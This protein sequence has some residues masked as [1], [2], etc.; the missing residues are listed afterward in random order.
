MICAGV[1]VISVAQTGAPVIARI[2]FTPV[3]RRR[4]D[5]PDI[6]APVMRYI[7]PG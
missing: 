5:F 7:C 3:I 6:F 4:V 1:K 2:R